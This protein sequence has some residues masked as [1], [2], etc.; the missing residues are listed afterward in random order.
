MLSW[1]DLLERE[2][3]IRVIVIDDTDDILKKLEETIN[4]IVS[5]QKIGFKTKLICR[6]TNFRG[7]FWESI[8]ENSSPNEINFE[9]KQILEIISKQ[10]EETAYNSSSRQIVAIKFYIYC[11]DGKYS[12]FII[13]KSSEIFEHLVL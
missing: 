13:V 11:D 5:N 2:N 9:I 6:G 10:V 12:K 3:D 8:Q 7:G 4:S 1:K